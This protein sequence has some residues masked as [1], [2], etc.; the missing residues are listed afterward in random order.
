LTSA[1][2]RPPDARTRSDV[3]RDDV[4]RAAC[5][6]DVGE[7]AG[8]RADVER[9]PAVYIEAEDVQRV[10]ELHAAAAHPRMIGQPQDDGGHLVDERARLG[11]G[12]AVHQDVAGEDARARALAGR[13]EPARDEQQVKPRPGHA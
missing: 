7:A 10:R 9:R 3:E 4:R 13:R 6:E 2:T 1:T 5:Q 11:D 8:R 12:R